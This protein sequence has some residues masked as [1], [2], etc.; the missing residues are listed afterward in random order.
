MRPGDDRSGRQVASG[1]TT[2]LNVF[3]TDFGLAKS[4]VIGSKLT[5]TGQALGTPAY[6]SPEQ[7]RG[8]VSSLT[9]ATDVW[10]LGCVLYEM[11]AGRA[12]FEGE[13]P[14]AVIAGVLAREPT[15]LRRRAGGIPGFLERVVIVSLAKGARRRYAHSGALRDDLERLLLGHRPRAARRIGPRTALVSAAAAGALLAG[16]AWRSGGRG[17][18]ARDADGVRASPVADADRLLE[19]AR[20]ARASDPR[21]AERLLEQALA[22][23]PGRS[24]CRLEKSLAHW[25]QGEGEEARR[26]WD[27]I[28]PGAGEREHARLYRALEACFRSDASGLRADL[29]ESELRELAAGSGHA[30]RLARGAWAAFGP[31]P[32]RALEILAGDPAWEA[33]LLRAY[34]RCD[35]LAT[36]LAAGVR[37]YDDAISRG[38]PVPWAFLNRGEAR[39]RLGDA[40]GAL[41]DLET[42]LR[43]RPDYA[44][45][46]HNRAD[47]RFRHGQW[48][49]AEADF[50]AALALRC[51][52]P[53]LLAARGAVRQSR[54]DSAG[55]LS[56]LTAALDARPDSVDALAIRAAVHL[57]AGQPDRAARDAEA[58]LRLAPGRG[59][60]HAVLG[61]ARRSLGDW[62]GAV[63][64]LREFL[65]LAPGDRRAEEIRGAIRECEEQSR[66]V[67][68]GAR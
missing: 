61:L 64:P 67:E 54:G 36:D 30:A 12:P 42:A 31:D 37:D 6:M 39:R 58:A 53:E 4:A 63:A 46:F 17:E 16:I 43:M 28:P 2:D 38:M 48:A 13:T 25:A 51:G 56:D 20:Q 35:E 47:L 66:A 68:R 14:P 1:S 32:A 10:S 60:A 40:A 62:R 41:L 45:A 23:Q 8:E 44:T 57:Y 5:R 15:R 52:D 21:E 19:R 59:E 3:L 65:R 34:V 49:E 55:A 9:P 11:L 26:E 18:S 24:D 33:A 22:V 27:A 29:A 7:A 50:T